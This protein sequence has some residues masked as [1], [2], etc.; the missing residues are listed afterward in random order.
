[1]IAAPSTMTP[2]PGPRASVARLAH[3]PPVEASEFRE[4]LRNLA[5]GVAI[6]ATGA[7]E[8]RR[9]LTA[10]SVTSICADPPCLLVSVNTKSEAHDSILANGYFGIS[11]LK[12]G[13]E[14]LARHFAGLD[15]VGGAD[16][17]RNAPWSEGATGA[18]LLDTAICAIDCVLQQHQ[19]V[20]SHGIFIGRIVATRRLCAGNPVIN[21]Q[22]EL[23]TLPLT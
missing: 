9:G 18:P 12:T 14:A 6:V 15:G 7:G 23:R 8:A 3:F 17:F 21:F 1:M 11:L 2:H 5:S 20:G 16:R 19:I 22:G 4:A 13:Q 10:S